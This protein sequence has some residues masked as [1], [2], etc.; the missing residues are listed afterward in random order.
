MSCNEGIRIVRI[1]KCDLHIYWDPNHLVSQL[2]F[3]VP[4]YDFNSI[5]DDYYPGFKVSTRVF[6]L[7]FSM[8]DASN[9]PGY[10]RLFASALLLIPYFYMSVF[11]EN[12]I[13]K[14]YFP[15]SDPIRIKQAVIRMNRVSY[16]FLGAL[17]LAVF[18][19]GELLTDKQ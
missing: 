6:D 11:V 1:G 12:Q 2:F 4:F 17:M 16:L 19:I 3:S 9:S 5:L 15:H 18:V 10:V 13:L 14:R 7:I 8:G